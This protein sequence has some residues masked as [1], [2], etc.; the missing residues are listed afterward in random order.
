M[1]FDSENEQDSTTKKSAKR[2][3]VEMNT[4]SEDVNN[5]S[6]RD[7]HKLMKNEIKES[8]ETKSAEE[9]VGFPLLLAVYVCTMSVHCTFFLVCV[10]LFSVHYKYRE[11]KLGCQI[12][13][14]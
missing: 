1:S 2:R 6:K 7:I 11:R 9:R 13:R 14:I 12:G 3:K 5:P 4:T 8:L 10:F